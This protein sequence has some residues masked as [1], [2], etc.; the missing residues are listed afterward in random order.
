MMLIRK[1]YINND[2]RYIKK[3]LKKCIKDFLNFMLIYHKNRKLYDIDFYLNFI[4]YNKNITH[5]KVYEYYDNHNN[6]RRYISMYCNNNISFCIDC[7]EHKTI[8]N[9]INIIV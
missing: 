7:L 1:T 8:V 9:K 3:I 5:Y 4:I 2:R 6:I